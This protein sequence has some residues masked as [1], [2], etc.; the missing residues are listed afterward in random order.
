[1]VENWYERQDELEYGMVFKSRSGSLLKLDHPV[2]G[3]GTKWFV[4]TF[5]NG[6]WAY[7]ED[8]V[9][10]ADLVQRVDDPVIPVSEATSL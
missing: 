2:P 4:A 3:D 9:E 5:W 8:T 6:S 10:P 1:M 7:M